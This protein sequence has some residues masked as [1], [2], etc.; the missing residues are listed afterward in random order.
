MAINVPMV[1]SPLGQGIQMGMQGFERG[2]GQLGQKL[3]MK[4]LMSGGNISPEEQALAGQYAPEALMGAHQQLQQQKLRQTQKEQV[5]AKNQMEMFKFATKQEDALEEKVR[6]IDDPAM[7]TQV[8]NQGMTTLRDLLK[9]QGQDPEIFFGPSFEADETFVEAVLQGDKDVDIIKTVNEKDEPVYGLLDKNTGKLTVTGAKI[10]DT[11][12]MSRRDREI[13]DY[14]KRGFNKEHAQDL[15]DGNVRLVTDP[16]TQEDYLINIATQ[17]RIELNETE[18][19]N[20]KADKGKPVTAE[21]E[22]VPPEEYKYEGEE[23]DIDVTKALGVAGW[24]ADIVN[25][26]ADLFGADLPFDDAN[27][28]AA[29]LD[30]LNTLTT[31][32]AAKSIAGKVNVHFQELINNLLVDPNKFFSGKGKSLNR[33]EALAHSFN[34]EAD[35]I[36][37][38]IKYSK[39]TPTIKTSSES[40][41][42]DLRKIAD[43]YTKFINSAKPRKKV[44]P[45]QFLIKKKSGVQ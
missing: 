39:V 9:D 43:E 29:K 20:L 21:G 4:Y 41:I 5:A 2:R 1:G 32:I 11:S 37:S 30:N 10:A 8:Y 26:L 17:E 38:H 35:R 31:T 27:K 24:S 14:I 16:I 42:D 12:K 36:E 23:Q 18:K 6:K 45:S 19:A 40:R 22:P 7:K 13:S 44:D 15:T 25:S 3:A 28:V 33:F 34:Q